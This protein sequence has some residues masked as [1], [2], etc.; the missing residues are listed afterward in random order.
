MSYELEKDPYLDSPD[1]VLKNLLEITNSDELARV[2]GNLTGIQIASMA[3]KPV[4]GDF[5]LGHLQAI[6]KRIFGSIYPW[7]GELRTVELSSGS[8]RFASIEYLPKA[9]QEVFDS[10]KSDGLLVNLSDEDY[11]S[12][13]AH[14]YSEVNILHPFR[15]GNGRTQ[16]AFF[17]LVAAQSGRFLAWD[18]LDADQNIQASIAAYNGDESKLTGMLAELVVQKRG[19]DLAA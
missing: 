17:S 11:T 14:Y 7:A 2:E 10:L 5:D 9:A 6:H 1:G 19:I 18:R 3:E 4:E 8:T 16:R 15:E 13:F 12:K